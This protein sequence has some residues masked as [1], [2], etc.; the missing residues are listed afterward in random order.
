MKMATQTVWVVR[1]AGH[2]PLAVRDTEAAALEAAEEAEEDFG[3]EC[4]VR[5]ETVDD[6]DPEFSHL[7]PTSWP[8]GP[9][10]SSP[11]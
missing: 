6:T 5:E 3:R 10:G 2:V 1:D 9:Q 11:G 4:S 8:G 7:F